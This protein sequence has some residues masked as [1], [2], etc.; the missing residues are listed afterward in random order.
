MSKLYS[1]IKNNDILTLSEDDREPI[2]D[3]MLYKGDYVMFMA[4]EKIGKTILSQQLVC[5]LSTGTPMFKTFEI[6]KPYKVWYMFNEVR[7]DELKE[8]FIAMKNGIDINTDNITLIPFKFLFNT[9]IGKQ[10]LNQIV[11][12]NKDNLPDVIILDALY[13]AIDGS[14]K[15]DNVANTFNHIFRN[16]ATDLGGCARIVVHHL[17]KPSK[18]QDGKF[19]KR[20][21]KD[22]FGSAFILA[23][24]DHCFRLEK[25]GDDPNTKDR[26]LKCETQRS[27]N[28]IE[29][30]RLRLIEP[31]PLYYEVVSVHIEEKAQIIKMLNCISKQSIKNIMKETKM[32]RAVAYRVIKELL[33]ENLIVKQGSKIK[34]FSINNTVGNDDR[35]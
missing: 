1:Y 7:M 24:V 33:E 10:Q 9:E 3:G 8:R 26:M 6:N 25:Y 5:S 19:R 34:Y 20:T 2:I 22:S 17:N 14:I 11:F 21:D 35:K 23:D 12:E 32:S 31:D 16:F 13:K 29:T 28:I 15:D 27:G 18:D 30:I 4:E